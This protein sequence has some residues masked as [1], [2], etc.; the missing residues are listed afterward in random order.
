MVTTYERN[1]NLGIPSDYEFWGD[2]SLHTFLA[3]SLFDVH[4]YSVKSVM[5]C[6]KQGRI[7]VLDIDMQVG[8][9]MLAYATCMPTKN[10]PC[11][12]THDILD[13]VVN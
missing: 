7:C 9:R 4:T 1:V 13:S 5:Q 2:G 11:V 3:L 12:F 10:R 8:S 6:N